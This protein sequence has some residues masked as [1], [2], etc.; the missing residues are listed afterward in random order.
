[1]QNNF[2]S[3]CEVKFECG[4]RETMKHIYVCKLYNNNREMTIQYDKVCPGNLKQKIELD[5]K[6]KENLVKKEELRKLFLY[7]YC[8]FS[9]MF[10][11]VRDR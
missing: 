7:Y 4:E 6:F 10:S 3:R 9:P 5:K 8:D 2:S 11:T 1:M